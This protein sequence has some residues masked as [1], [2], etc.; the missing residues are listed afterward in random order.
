[1]PQLKKGKKRRAQIVAIRLR[2]E[3]E[4][5]TELLEQCGMLC[6]AIQMTCETTLRDEERKSMAVYYDAQRQ[7][8]ARGKALSST[9]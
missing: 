3:E 5:I 4:R 8:K 7:K 9:S 1:M 6:E 2:E